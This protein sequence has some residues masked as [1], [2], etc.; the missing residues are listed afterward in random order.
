MVFQE[1]Q[2]KL[3]SSSYHTVRNLSKIIFFVNT[4]SEA[5]AIADSESDKGGDSFY[6]SAYLSVPLA[7][8]ALPFSVLKDI[9]SMGLF[10]QTLLGLVGAFGQNDHD[11][12]LAFYNK[13]AI[14]KAMKVFVL[15]IL[16]LPQNIIYDICDMFVI[17]TR[18]KILPQTIS[19]L[20]EIANYSPIFSF[21]L[22]D[23]ATKGFGEIL[24]FAIELSID[25][26]KRIPESFAD[27]LRDI[28]N[29]LKSWVNFVDNNGKKD[30]SDEHY[31]E[32]SSINSASVARSN[33]SNF[34]G[35]AISLV[36]DFKG[37]RTAQE[38]QQEDAKHSYIPR[39]ANS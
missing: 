11:T 8:L 10:T 39:A 33:S 31:L 14:R 15:Q 36:P 4:V 5:L 30:I 26:I 34:L 3:D 7:I 2:N 25:R 29:Y 12:N 9:A 23:N 19:Q 6:L 28:Y 24:G 35:W 18:Y 1:L 37:C 38:Q 16:S 13:D 21:K 27:D 32:K 20:R 17:A 22:P